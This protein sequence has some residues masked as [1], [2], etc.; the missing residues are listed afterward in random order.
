MIN[1]LKAMAA[2][3]AVAVS[4]EAQAQTPATSPL[5]NHGARFWLIVNEDNDHFFKSDSALMTR[6]SLEEIFAE[7]L[8]P[9]AV[10]SRPRESVEIHHDFP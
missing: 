1:S 7:G 4:M 6:Q 3:L 9:E 8:S 5:G 10:R 2:A